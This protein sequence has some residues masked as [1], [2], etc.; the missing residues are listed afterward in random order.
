[1][2]DLYYIINS[3]TSEY[4]EVFSPSWEG[5]WKQQYIHI[6]D[7]EYI[8][9]DNPAIWSHQFIN[10]IPYGYDLCRDGGYFRLFVDV[11]KFTDEDI[12]KAVTQLRHQQD[13][14]SLHV[15]KIKGMLK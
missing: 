2:A 15:V 7:L 12:R 8:D 1:M 3:K 6:K 13:V 10:G 4:I 5:D 14:V 9:I 11:D